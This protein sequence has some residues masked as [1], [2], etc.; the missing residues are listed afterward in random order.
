MADR[1][2]GAAL[3]PLVLVGLLA[4]L[5]Y[6]LDMAS[7]PPATEDGRQR[8]EPDT[9]IDTF[10]VRRFGPEGALQHTLRARQLHHY[11]GNDS[12]V[13]L[14][15]ELTYHRMPVTRVTAREARIDGDGKR[16]ELVDDVRITRGAMRG[17]PETVLTTTHLEIWP[18]DEIAANRAPVLIVQGESQVRGIGMHANN[19]TGEYV[20]DGPVR[21]IFHRVRNR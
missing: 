14:A 20:L 17:K 11:P 3:F 7:R 5:T 6:W 1:L 4:G 18:D 9:L 19:Q 10:E 21:G 8:R 16:V 15:P 2:H 13:V 12:S